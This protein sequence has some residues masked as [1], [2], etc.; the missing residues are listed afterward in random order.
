M[1]ELWEAHSRTQ[2]HLSGSEITVGDIVLVND[3]NHPQTFL[4]VM[5]LI[6]SIDEHVRGACI[7]VG[8]TR[9]ALR[10]PTLALYLLEINAP[11]SDE[12][13]EAHP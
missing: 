11:P 9:S 5:A 8:A 2:N 7:H 12:L 6:R 13:V 10:R 4:R 3:P 1:T